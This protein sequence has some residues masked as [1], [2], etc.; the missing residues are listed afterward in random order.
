MNLKSGYFLLSSIWICGTLLVAILYFN[1]CKE[2]DEKKGTVRN[3]LFGAVATSLIFNLF[4]WPFVLIPM[5]EYYRPRLAVLFRVRPA[6]TLRKK[7]ERESWQ[8]QADDQQSV[9]AEVGYDTGEEQPFIRVD[10]CHKRVD[11]R[12]RMVA[13]RETKPT[14]WFPMKRPTKEEQAEGAKTFLEEEGEI[15]EK[16][17]SFRTTP[18]IKNAGKYQIEFRILLRSGDYQELSPLTLIVPERCS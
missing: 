10:A 9:N 7:G 16:D 12:A 15:A 14:E 1:W 6:W 4:A 2:V 3:S 8:W 17:F 13:P 11:F 5:L 18:Q